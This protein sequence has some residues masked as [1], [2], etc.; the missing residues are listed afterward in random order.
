DLGTTTLSG[1]LTLDA[2]GA[3]TQS[4]AVSVGGQTTLDAASVAFSS[5]NNN[6]NSLK[7]TTTGDASFKD[8]TDFAF[9]GGASS[10]GGALTITAGGTISQTSAIS[11]AGQ[12]TITAPV[13]VLDDAA[14][15]FGSLQFSVTGAA[16]FKDAN[17]LVF[18]GGASNASNL[19]VTA[20]GAITQTSTLSISGA[21][22][23]TA[24]SVD[25]D[26]LTNDTAVLELHTTGD[27]T[28]KD[29][30]GLVFGNG[31]SDVDG[32]LTI[33]A[34]GAINQ[35]AALTVGGLASFSGA[36][37]DLNDAA[38]DFNSLQFTTAGDAAFRD[39]NDLVF[40][41]GASS[42]ASL[43][44]LAGGAITQ[45]SAL[46]IT[47]QTTL[48]AASVDLDDVFNNFNSLKVA[49]TGD[50]SF[51]DVT[52]FAFGGGASSVG[53]ALTITAGGTISQ[54]SAVSVAGQTTITAP[55]VVLDDA[56]ND[57]NTLQFSVG[58]DATF[59][60]A[61]DLFFG[62]GASN[63][64]NLTVTAV[65]A[66]TQTSAVSVGGALTL[67]ADS[68]DLDDQTN[69][70]SVIELHVVGSASYKDADGV[71]FGNGASDVGGDLTIIAGTTINQGA[72]LSVGGL[73]SFSGTNITLTNGANDFATVQFSTAGSASLND[74]NAIEFD[75]ASNAAN[76]TVTAGGAITQT[77]DGAL[78]ISGQTTLS[79]TSVDLDDA[80]NDFNTL[81]VTTAGDAAFNDASGLVFGGGASSVGG[82]LNV[83]AGGDVTQTDKLSVTGLATFDAAG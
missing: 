83:T 8:L 9:G 67:T 36:S 6:F 11:V 24:A 17:D 26:D 29:A 70:S 44:V 52:D 4:G 10:V 16:T 28:F 56:A 12:T 82:K 21:T 64:A 2:V 5:F 81:Q 14:N 1:D 32:D 3:I 79:G 23:L 40:A 13:V 71:V 49:T 51:K 46:T 35:G 37:I 72:A 39:Q 27:A 31:A 47:G 19:T 68:V 59:K 20:V 73:A 22:I 25:L 38:N 80:A 48:D 66:I 18:G 33:S 58:G 42:A 50:A 69:N 30:D 43:D 61:N 57:F 15:D 63:A 78:S 74:A 65:G 62:G 75:D 45:T 34:G 76:L 54:T 7:V 41:G 53:G 60:D 55:V 77:A